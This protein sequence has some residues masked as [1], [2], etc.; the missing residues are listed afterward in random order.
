MKKVIFSLLAI[1]TILLVS[2]CKERM[3]TT[4]ALVKSVND[5]TIVASIDKYDI[6]FDILNANFLNGAVMRGDSVSIEYVGD[7]R[8]KTVKALLINLVPPKPRYMKPGI[9]KSK[10]LKTEPMSKTE[11]ENLDA[12][13]EE[14][15]KHGH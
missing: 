9:D 8:D 1:L 3:E 12:F 2:S 11:V 4:R 15:K 6:T 10:P 14:A 13:V 5:S 7:L